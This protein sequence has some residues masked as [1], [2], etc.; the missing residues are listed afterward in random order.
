VICHCDPAN[1]GRSNLTFM[2]TE[3][4][5][6]F[7]KGDV[8]DDSTTR[9]K[10]SRD[11][12][13]FEI[14][15]KAVI[16]PKDAEDIQNLVKFASSKPGVSLTARSGGTDMTGGPLTESLVLEF[17]KYFNQVKEVGDGYAI[18]QPGVYYRDFE[19]ETM[20][21]GQI[22]PS[23]PA[24]REICAIGGMV[25]NDSGGEKSLVYG[26]THDYVQEL[27]VVFADG[28][29]YEVKK[30]SKAE[31]NKKK[32]QQN[33]EGEIYKK[34]YDLVTDNEELLKAS[35][36]QVSKNSSGY[37]LWDVWDGENFDLTRLIVGSQGTLGLVT[38]VKFKLVPKKKHTG[39]LVVFMK[40]LG[41]L[42]DFV[43]VVLPFQPGSFESFD[44]ATLKLA[45]KF[46]PGFLK[47]MGA[48]N[49]F[50]LGLS[51]LPEVWT[52]LTYGMPKLVCLIEFE[53]DTREEVDRKLKE[54]NAALAKFKVKTKIAA[55][56]NESR[57]YW[58]IR[59]E[60]FNLLRHKVAGKQTAPFID[61]VIVKP[62]YLP[63]FLPKL[64]AITDKYRLLNTIAGHV[65]NGNFHI[66][67]LMVLS[68]EE[69][70]KKI[71]ACLDEVINLILEYKGSIT[72]E[73]N[74]GLIRSPYLPKMFGAEMYGI[75][76]EVKKIFDPKNIFNPG[77][78]VGA[79]LDYAFKHMKRG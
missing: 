47:Q 64:H 37:N 26:K 66:I 78:K 31:L 61:D 25:A 55:T 3:E 49:L 60:S 75:F 72:A 13:L 35:K 10:Y 29:E 20:K 44:D 45:L 59:R 53:E 48:K 22:M 67:P 40:D 33:F 19:K 30:L 11:A 70:R 46:F 71:P 14:T 18:T 39:M 74:D 32:R 12:S 9:Q 41:I 36:P 4:I 23:Y 27:K 77:K 56:E 5:R 28:K 1:G 69:D 24:S 62:E 2:P 8:I 43:N 17:D 68:N 16:F 51:F 65:G 79:S 52:I 50:S 38:E 58:L 63:E 73:H 42:G 6:K 21:T 15:P 34:I 7:L 57:K 76:E 54:L